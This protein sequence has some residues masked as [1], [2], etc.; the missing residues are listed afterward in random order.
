MEIFSIFPIEHPDLWEFYKK[1]QSCHWVAEEVNLFDD[2]NDWKKMSANEKKFLS[3][4]LAFFAQSDGIVNKNLAE[5]FVCEIPYKEAK[6]FYS[7][8]VAMENVHNETYSLLIETYISDP[9]EKLALLRATNHFPVI[10]AKAE[11]ALK[12]VEDQEASLEKRLVA[13]I[14]VEGLFF[15]GSFCS[16]FWLKERGLMKG[17]T[18]SNEL[19]SR[20]EGLHVEFGVHIYLKMSSE[21]LAARLQESVIFEMMEE[22]V[23]IET[24]FICES[25][26]C[27]M[28]GMNQGLMIEYIRFVADKLLGMMRYNKLYNVQKCPFYFMENISMIGKTNFF[29]RKNSEYMIS[30]DSSRLNFAANEDF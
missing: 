26:S 19:I 2:L 10:R 14:I 3:M 20:D 8:Q 12:W 7:W 6:F 25:L 27:E 16:L 11:W 30:M 28:I 1:A 15:S 24:Q 4:I 13:F 21:G 29:E 5:R 22:A 23:A 17:L 9:E 18:F